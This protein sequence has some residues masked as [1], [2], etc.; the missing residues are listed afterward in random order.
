MT[1][2]AHYPSI[3]SIDTHDMREHRAALELARHSSSAS[4]GVL[5]PP[6][7]KSPRHGGLFLYP[8]GDNM[9][10]FAYKYTRWVLK[11]ALF[12]MTFLAFLHFFRKK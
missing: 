11:S 12:Q 3:E 8:N 9:L 2:H 4:S 5:P 6:R 10:A 7:V 1:V